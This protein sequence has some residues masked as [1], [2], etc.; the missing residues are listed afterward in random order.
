MAESPVRLLFVINQFGQGGSERYLFELCSALD[1]R[2]FDVRILTRTGVDRTGFYYHRLSALDIP[3]YPILPHV[4]DVRRLAPA[5]SSWRP[6]R[7]GRNRVSSW[8][9]GWRVAEMVRSC[10]IV[11]CIQI[12]NFLALQDTLRNHQGVVVHLMSSRF[13]YSYDPY[14]EVRQDRRQRFVTFDQSQNDEIRSI[15]N[16]E[17][18]Q[19][20]LSMD[21]TSYPEITI[22]EV[23]DRPLK[24][25][26]VTRLSREKPLEPLFRAFKELLTHVDATLHVYGGGDP[27]IF[28]GEIRRLDIERRVKFEG[29]RE[30]LLA[31]LANDQLSMCWLMSV[32]TLLGYASIELAA[33]GMPMAFW[34]FGSWS[35]ER[36]RR[37]TGGAMHSFDSVREF[38]EFSRACLKNRARLVE[39]GA[40]LRRH[41]R[42]TH[43]INRNIQALQNYYL[44]VSGRSL[45]DNS[46]R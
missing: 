36:I 30:N 41:I 31:M 20:P 43:D 26:I 12:E 35:A 11:A 10:D 37:E 46:R 3:I 15:R 22:P 7:V 29:H 1:R 14:D 42:D 8:L 28:A 38:V 32:G 17:T 9:A 19:W 34:N 27:S 24:I 16:A 18:F 45:L 40:D 13:Q 6:Y 33:S 5:L 44:R 25:G 39:I 2:C 4:P 23:S 21:F